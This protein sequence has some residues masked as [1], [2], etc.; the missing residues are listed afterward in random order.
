MNQELKQE[1]AA[2]SLTLFALLHGVNDQY[3]AFLA[4]LMPLLLERFGFGLAI[5]GL[6][7][8]VQSTAT[9]FAELV[10]G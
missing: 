2:G 9:P 10:F 3:T 5:A 4:A 7:A 6:L 8:A 1:R